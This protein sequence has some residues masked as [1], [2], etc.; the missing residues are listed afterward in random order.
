MPVAEFE[1]LVKRQRLRPS[2]ARQVSN[3]VLA[4]LRLCF[5]EKF[6]RHS[7]AEG[8]V[9]SGSSMQLPVVARQPGFC[10]PLADGMFTLGMG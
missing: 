5:C 4:T 2:Q 3:S 6:R 10:V 8:V 1:L 7:R 9:C